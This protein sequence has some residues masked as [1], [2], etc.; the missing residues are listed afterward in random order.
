MR[1]GGKR[2]VGYWGYFIGRTAGNFAMSKVRCED[3]EESEPEI[4]QTWEEKNQ[5]RLEGSEEFAAA[6]EKVQSFIDS[7]EPFTDHEFP[8]TDESIAQPG[9]EQPDRHY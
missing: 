2:A 9:D 1:T 7:G 8:P 5:E 4:G 6:M 3:S